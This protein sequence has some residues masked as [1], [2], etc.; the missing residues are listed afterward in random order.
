MEREAA[1][2]D[3]LAD[4]MGI[5]WAARLVGTGNATVTRSAAEMRAE[6]PQ[7]WQVAFRRWRVSAGTLAG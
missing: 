2:R 6:A 5:S 3:A 4:G 7:G 1:V